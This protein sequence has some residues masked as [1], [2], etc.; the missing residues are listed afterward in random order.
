MTRDTIKDLNGAIARLEHGD[1]LPLDLSARLLEAGI[2]V[3]ALE[4]QVAP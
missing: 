4:R 3:G 1:P 2:D